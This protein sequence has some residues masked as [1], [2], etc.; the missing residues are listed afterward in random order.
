MEKDLSGWDFQSWL[1]MQA[2]KTLQEAMEDLEGTGEPKGMKDLLSENR[3][4]II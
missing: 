4:H 1:N 2:G 3:F